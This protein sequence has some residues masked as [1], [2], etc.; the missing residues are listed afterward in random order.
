MEFR[1]IYEGAL[2]PSGGSNSRAHAKHEIRRS[3]HPQLR[4]LWSMKPNL[5]Q[6]ADHLGNCAISDLG[7]RGTTEQERFV[8]GISAIGKKWSMA[9]Y[10]LVPLV[11]S[12]M[13][14]RCSLDIL[15]LRPEEGR[16]IFN[17]GDIDGQLKTLFDALRLP[18]NLGEAGG[19]G[20]QED[21]T[22]LFCL[23]EDDR[24]ISEVRVTTDQLLLLPNQR[25]VKANDAHVVIHV[26]LNHKNARAFDNYFG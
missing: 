13:A 4:R 25:E 7:P 21:E 8:F 26:K 11:T 12:D 5:R 18:A 20:P 16:F 10:D 9:G 24:L 6:L 19:T 1:L 2:L 14:L 3:L 17:Q 22:P 15:L 23:L